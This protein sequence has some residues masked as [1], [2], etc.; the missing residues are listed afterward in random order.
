VGRRLG[1]FGLL[2]N[3]IRFWPRV[4]I[5]SILVFVAFFFC[6]ALPLAVILMIALGGPSVISFFLVLAVAGIQVWIV[7][8]LFVIF[9]F[10]QQCAVLDGL[11]WLATFRESKRLAR[12]GRDLPWFKRPLWRGVFISSL[13]VAC[14]LAL[15]FPV[16]WP[17][18]REYFHIV[19]TTQDPQALVQALS[20]AP[21]AH[22]FNGVSFGLSLLQAILRPL[23][24]IAFVLLYFDA[25]SR[26]D[27]EDG[28]ARDTE[29]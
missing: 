9:L 4:A 22:G 11:T 8:R 14:A 6:T 29:R 28:A 7:G 25:R 20:A 17:V 23:L 3:A 27:Q 13:W 19:S 24:G 1:F 2:N 5:C 12:S 18:M 10:W 15:A 26:V 16:A 21:K